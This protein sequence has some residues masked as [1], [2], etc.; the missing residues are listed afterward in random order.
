VE[1]V[2][3]RGCVK[4][5]PGTAAGGFRHLALLYQG[6][7][8]YLAAVRGWIQGARARAEPVFVAVP[9]PVSA[10]LRSQ[11]PEAAADVQFADMAELGRNP[12]RIITAFLTFAAEHAGR[13]VCCL[14]EQVWPSR[15]AAELRENARNEALLNVAMAGCGPR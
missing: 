11:L 3:I 10:Q 9:G 8:D 12:A 14:S 13:Q 15:S 6:T 1:T 7:A 4:A 2:A 5:D